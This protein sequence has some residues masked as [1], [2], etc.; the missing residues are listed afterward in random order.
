MDFNRSKFVK[1]LTLLVFNSTSTPVIKKGYPREFFQFCYDNTTFGQETWRYLQFRKISPNFLLL[2]VN[3]F[4]YYKNKS[5]I[6]NLA[7]TYL[8]L[9]VIQL[10]GQNFAILDPP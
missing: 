5:V 1:L 10:R 8:I 3:V 7:F 9:G 4:Q 6:L 2:A